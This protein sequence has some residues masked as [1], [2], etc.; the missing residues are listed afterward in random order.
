[1]GS[2]AAVSTLL[3]DDEARQLALN[4]VHTAHH[5]LNFVGVVHTRNRKHRRPLLDGHGVLRERRL[6][7]LSWRLQRVGVEHV[8]AHEVRGAHLVASSFP[9]HERRHDFLRVQ[10]MRSV[11]V[12]A[13]AIFEQKKQRQR[14]SRINDRT[15]VPDLN[16]RVQ[17]HAREILEFSS[18]PAMLVYLGSAQVRH[19]TERHRLQ[20]VD[21]AVTDEDAVLLCVEILSR[22]WNKSPRVVAQIYTTRDG[23]FALRDLL[24]AAELLDVSTNLVKSW[25]IGQ[26]LLLDTVNLGEAAVPWDRFGVVVVLAVHA[27]PDQSV[28]HDLTILIDYTDLDGDVLALQRVHHES[29][30]CVARLIGILVEGGSH[31]VHFAV[32]SKVL[33]RA[34]KHEEEVGQQKDQMQEVYLL[35]IK[36]LTVAAGH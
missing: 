4:H 14:A 18:L 25:R 31:L 8:D 19:V 11:H 28:E 26:P 20:V 2:A 21:D 30:S 9:R 10:E 15:V 24:L 12:K 5:L 16:L 1:M 27:R 34:K 3:V 23:S 29:S 35:A 7:W 13:L 22:H 33:G 32:N 17:V 36:L 6:R